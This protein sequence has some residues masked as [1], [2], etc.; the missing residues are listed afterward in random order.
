MADNSEDEGVVQALLERFNKIGLPRALA[1]KDKVDRGE[2][3]SDMDTQYLASVNDT[4]RKA[5]PLIAR[6]PEYEALSIK[7][8]GLYQ[9]ILAKALENARK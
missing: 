1:L 8:I 3:L 4:F 6:H 2:E 5:Q 7:A 9:E